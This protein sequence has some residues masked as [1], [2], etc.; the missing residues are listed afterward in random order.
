M[1]IWLFGKSSEFSQ[2][3][4]S[5]W[6]KS[7]YN[8][9]EFGRENINYSNPELFIEQ[10]EKISFPDYVVFNVNVG[11]PF[12]L[13]SPI[14]KQNVNTQ[15]L[16]FGEWFQNNLDINFFKVYIF[17]WLL[18]N[19]FKGEVAHI[20]SQIAKDTNPD[21]KNLLNYKMQ[22]A[23]DYQIIQNQRAYGI[24]SYG[25]CPAS[26]QDSVGWPKYIASLI[27]NSNKDKSWLYG[28]IKDEKEINY[29]SY[30]PEGLYDT[31][32]DLP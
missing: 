29:I 12:E 27:T 31:S 16:I 3:M 7:N 32:N 15:K 22:R 28:I 14:H 24:N 5:Q 6:Q 4:T 2:H 17:D 11:V 13:N 1:N 25:I 30:P 23:L 8:V 18:D 9:I 19:N 20:T 26:I 10:A 21:Y